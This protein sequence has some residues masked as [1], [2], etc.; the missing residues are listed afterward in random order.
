MYP[1]HQRLKLLS[2]GPTKEIKAVCI[3]S[4]MKDVKNCI[5]ADAML[6]AQYSKIALIVITL[7]MLDSLKLVTRL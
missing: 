1:F 6:I 4:K 7:A 2:I 5:A 3:H